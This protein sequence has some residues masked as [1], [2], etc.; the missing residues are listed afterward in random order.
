MGKAPKWFTAAAVVA[1]LW[2]LLGCAAF[3]ADLRLTPEDVAKLG[4]AQQA[5]HASRPAWSV[6]ATGIAV[7]A[8]ALG[9]VGLILRKR[10]SFALLVLSL[11]GVVVQDISMFAMSRAGAAP[12]T[13]ALVLQGVVFVVAVALVLLARKATKIAWLS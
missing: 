8:G 2:N 13:T 6:A 3:Y 5:M 10:W 11:V 7:I 9:C 1:L 4:A 12:D